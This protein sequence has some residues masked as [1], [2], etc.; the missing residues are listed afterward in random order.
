MS[1]IFFA[2]ANG[3]PSPCYAPFFDALRSNGFDIDSIETIGLNPKFPVTNNWPHL[4]EELGEEITSRYQEPV[5]GIGHSLGGLL[6]YLLANKQPAFY[7]HIILLDPPIINGWQN[8]VWW[9]LKRL[10]LSDRITPAGASKNRR[11]HFKDYQDAYDNLRNKRLFKDFPEASFEAYIKHGFKPD[12]KGALTLAVDLETELSLFRTASDDLWRYR[13]KLQ[14]PS[15]YLTAEGSEF[16][17][18][19]FA[20]NLS[21]R[22]GMDYQ[23]LKGGHLFPQER[24]E[25][26]AEVIA[27][28]LLENQ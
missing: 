21:A 6:T 22:A 2:H 20:R 25:E 10:G 24:P 7:S 23:V 9:L 5:I 18:K 19:P 1:T 12:G 13:Q 8:I 26:T 11:T 27:Q 17:R 16:S 3:F 4:V 28:W 14:M 15:L